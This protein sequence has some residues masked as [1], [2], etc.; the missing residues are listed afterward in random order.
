MLMVYVMSRV[1]SS[2]IF[3]ACMIVISLLDDII[4]I[5]LCQCEES[6]R[7]V[8]FIVAFNMECV[9]Y[10]SMIFILF[11]KLLSLRILMCFVRVTAMVKV[12]PWVVA[13][14]KSGVNMTMLS[15]PMA[16]TSLVVRS[17][18]LMVRCDMW[19]FRFLVFSVMLRMRCWYRCL[20]L[21]FLIESCRMMLNW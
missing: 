18:A 17:R 21:L 8:A 19:L 1:G 12:C 5:G 7:L 9:E 13:F 10:M 3:R 4:F 14:L 15:R 20:L 2:H 16:L 6:G 11:H